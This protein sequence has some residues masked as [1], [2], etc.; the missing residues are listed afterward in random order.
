MKAFQ[1]TTWLLT[2][3]LA[4]AGAA[5]TKLADLSAVEDGFV[6]SVARIRPSVVSIAVPYQPAGAEGQQHAALSGVVVRPGYIVSLSNL[7][8]WCAQADVT[9]LDGHEERTRVVGYDPVYGLGVLESP[10]KDVA[11]ATLAATSSLRPGS[12]VVMVG[13]AFGLR[14]SVSWGLVSG[15]RPNVQVQGRPPV[16]MIQMTAPVNPGDSGCAVVNLRGELVGLASSSY[17]AS[18]SGQAAPHAGIS[19]AVPMASLAPSIDQIVATGRVPRGWLGLAITTVYLPYSRRRAVQVVG[20][21]PNSP[22]FRAGVQAGDLVLSLGQTP[23]HTMEQ[24]EA[25]VLLTRPGQ[26]MLLEVV[27]QGQRSRLRAEVGQWQSATT[28]PVS[29]VDSLVH[30]APRAGDIRLSGADRAPENAL[31]RRRLRQMQE[32]ILQLLKESER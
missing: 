8:A 14:H 11:P 26:E 32:E 20:V 6:R 7:L 21:A 2:C 12:W 25:L 31:L 28:H 24:L 3:L 27:R 29:D 23:V 13:N 19:F 30:P 17:G 22:G 4:G 10:R 9:Y 5:Q 16:D 1:T 18:L 15:M